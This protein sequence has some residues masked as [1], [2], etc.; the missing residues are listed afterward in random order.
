MFVGPTHQPTNVSGLAY[1]AAMTPYVR[2]LPDKH[3][4]HTSVE[5]LT[6]VIRN[7]NVGPDKYKKLTNEC[8]FL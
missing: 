3:K 4:L 6:N 7:I 1:V 8:L 5:K 2:W